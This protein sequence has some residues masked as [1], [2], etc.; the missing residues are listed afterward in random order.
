[1]KLFIAIFLTLSYFATHAGEI[2]PFPNHY[3]GK[4]GVM[5][6]PGIITIATHDKEFAGLVPVI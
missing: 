6:V 3:E 5:Q 1:M 2:I 4:P